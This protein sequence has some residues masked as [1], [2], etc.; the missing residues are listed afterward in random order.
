[1][2]RRWE[3]YVGIAISEITE[4]PNPGV[5][6][7]KSI[8]EIP[9]PRVE[10]TEWDD[11]GSTPVANTETDVEIKELY[12]ESELEPNEFHYHKC[13]GNYPLEVV[14]PELTPMYSSDG[15]IIDEKTREPLMRRY[16]YKYK[17]PYA[18]DGKP[19]EGSIDEYPS[20]RCYY[21]GR[22]NATVPHITMG[23]QVLVFYHR[24]NQIFYWKEF[25]RD[26]VLPRLEKYRLF[27]N[28]EQKVWKS[29]DV[30]INNQARPNDDNTYYLEFDT[31]NKHILIATSNSDGEK[32]RYWL[33]MNPKDMTF[34][35]WDTD[36]NRIQIDSKE[37]RIYMRNR[38]QT[39]VDI[40]NQDINIWS[41][42]S[43]TIESDTINL[44]GRIN[45]NE[46]V[47]VDPGYK[48]GQVSGKLHQQ[49]HAGR[50]PALK[51]AGPMTGNGFKTKYVSTEEDFE[52]PLKKD[53]I[54]EWHIENELY[55]F[56]G[57]I[58]KVI[59]DLLDANIKQVK[60]DHKQVTSTVDEWTMNNKIGKIIFSS[61]FS[62]LGASEK[63]P[64]TL[65][66][67]VV[68]PYSLEGPPIHPWAT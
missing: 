34:S 51:G 29:P 21:F 35:I 50:G 57:K 39:T 63:V 11:G 23:E 30:G 46:T 44:T 54:K 68:M 1:M 26:N 9:Y 12:D 14:I 61:M 25:G 37:H 53:K 17:Y 32:T 45:Y 16:K 66:L 10:Q 33:K 40:H 8:P 60:H 67:K 27:A 31:I 24:G 56:K 15:K 43:I 47:G 19:F 58:M 59:G 48:D 65:G 36:G 42:N 55:D 4:D 64:L 20:V 38:E 22:R 7:E 18:V 2:D 3:M 28:D 49:D 13:L 6:V 52:T 5:Q 41:Q 62:I